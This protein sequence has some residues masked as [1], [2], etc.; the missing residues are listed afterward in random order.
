MS[1]VFAIVQDGAVVNAIVAESWPEGIDVTDV[2]P[3][4]APGWT[5]DGTTWAR[6]VELPPEPGV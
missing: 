6:P 2:D 5:Y 3:R 4:P 1:R